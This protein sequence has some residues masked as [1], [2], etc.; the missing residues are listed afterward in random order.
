[1]TYEQLGDV[2][3]ELYTRLKNLNVDDLDPSSDTEKWFEVASLN[4]ELNRYQVHML[5]MQS[6][7]RNREFL[8]P[9]SRHVDK[10]R[11]DNGVYLIT[12]SPPPE[13]ETMEFINAVHS[14]VNLKVVKWAKY[15]IEQRGIDYPHDFHGIHAH[16]LCERACKPSAFK[17]ELARV[18]NKFFR[19]PI[20][21]K[22][23]NVENVENGENDKVL[24]YIKG[25]K[26]GGRNKKAEKV[27]CD[28]LFRKDWKLDDLYVVSRE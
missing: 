5:R 16:I 8:N 1:M 19:K 24:R 18:I 13:N 7:R 12:L 3:E 23:K 26:K 20:L 9:P 15:S 4:D 25:G 27:K 6:L 11:A 10:R 21:K 17:K 2:V 28:L 22:Q 14:F